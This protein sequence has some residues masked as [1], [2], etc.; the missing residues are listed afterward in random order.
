MEHY[1]V[2]EV[3]VVAIGNRIPVLDFQRFG[4]RRFLRLYV[5]RPEAFDWIDE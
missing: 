5:L 2:E 4:R 3:R 1:F